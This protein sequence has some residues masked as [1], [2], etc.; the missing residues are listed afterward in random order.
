MDV[1]KLLI[2]VYIII[3]VYYYVLIINSLYILCLY[4]LNMWIN[5]FKDIC[6]ILENN[7]LLKI[8]I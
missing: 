6:F 3:L 1:I 2:C 5:F 4:F 7:Y 8:K